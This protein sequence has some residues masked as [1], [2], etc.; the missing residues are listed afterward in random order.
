MMIVP[1]P[2]PVSSPADSNKLDEARREIT[3]LRDAVVDLQRRVEKQAVLLRALC[4]VLG[5]RHELTE[6][7]LL[8]RFRQAETT[9]ANTPAKLCAHCRRPV[10]QRHHRCLYCGEAYAVQSAFEL[11]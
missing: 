8:D 11:L 1:Y 9:K 5:E 3:A 4:D 7:E 2:I 10:N 6:A